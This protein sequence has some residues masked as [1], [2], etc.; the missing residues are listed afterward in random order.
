[1]KSEGIS[2]SSYKSLKIISI[3]PYN[4]NTKIY[5]LKTEENSTLAIPVT[6][7]VKARADINGQEVAKSYTPINFNNEKGHFDILVKVGSAPV[8]CLFILFSYSIAC[9][10]F[11]IL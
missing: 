9:G 1:M 6:S 8:C 10:V 3:L 11:L 4:H 5:R 7:C 2:P